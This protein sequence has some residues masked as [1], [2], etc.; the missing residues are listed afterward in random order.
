MTPTPDKDALN[1]STFIVAQEDGQLHSDLTDQL[2]EIVAQLNNAVLD[3]GGSHVAGLTIDL[4]FKIEGG[5]IEVKA[6]IKT[7]M[8][9]ENRPRSIFWATPNNSLKAKNPKQ[10]DMF[11]DVNKTEEVRKL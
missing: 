7:K 1:F 6:A 10:I 8:P 4:G 9:K 5:A 2:R 3:Q 11:R